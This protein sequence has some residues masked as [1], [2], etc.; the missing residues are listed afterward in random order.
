MKRGV[1]FVILNGDEP[2]PNGYWFVR[3]N[4]YKATRYLS[5]DLSTPCTVRG[6]K[7][8]CQQP[9]GPPHRLLRSS[10]RFT[11]GELKRWAEQN[12]EQTVGLNVKRPRPFGDPECLMPCEDA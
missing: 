4:I 2:R 6:L 3:I 12:P 11:R 7:Q 5:D 1:S 10:L 8:A 9:A